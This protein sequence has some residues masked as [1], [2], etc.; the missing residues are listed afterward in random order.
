M[1][2]VFPYRNFPTPRPVW[3]LDGRVERPR[4]VLHVALIGPSQTCARLSL[5][6]SGADDTIFPE[7]LAAL[8]GIDLTGAPTGSASGVGLVGVG[9]RYAEVTL[10]ITDGREFRQW[11]ARVGFTSTKLKRPLLGFAGFLK[12]F[13]A[14]FH[15]DREEVELAV[16]SL[17]PGT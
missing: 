2:L 12:F 3:P 10:R 14:T 11:Q 6:D 16:N 15:G 1:S 8:A 5:L 17:Y 13:T 9:V 4:P 7:D